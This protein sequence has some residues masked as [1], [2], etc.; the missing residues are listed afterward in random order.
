MSVTL[1]AK[2]ISFTRVIR[3]TCVSTEFA[4]FTGKN[5]QVALELPLPRALAASTCRDPV[6][7]RTWWVRHCDA[8]GFFS[9]SFVEFV[10]EC[11][12]KLDAAQRIQCRRLGA[13]HQ[14]I[15]RTDPVTFVDFLAWRRHF[16]TEMTVALFPFV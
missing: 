16:P 3:N 8:I 9:I 15:E 2:W 14:P 10:E 12:R 1:S 13:I 5:A 11:A 4:P 6:S 7:T